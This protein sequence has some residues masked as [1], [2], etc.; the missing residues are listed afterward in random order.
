MCYNGYFL[1]EEENTYFECMDNYM[2]LE[3][4]PKKLTGKQKTLIALSN[5]LKGEIDLELF[6]KAYHQI[7]TA[8]YAADSIPLGYTETGMVLAGLSA[9]E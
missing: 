2:D 9:S 6:A 5:C 1:S 4:Y 7:I 8:G 3:F